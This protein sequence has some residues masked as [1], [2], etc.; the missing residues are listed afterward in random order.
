MKKVKSKIPFNYLTIKTT[1]SRIE[2]GLLAIPVSLISMFSQN[3]NKIYIIN[4]L[5]EEEIKKFTP[6]KSSSRE[7]RIGGLKNFYKRN[8]VVSGDEIVV[9]L[10]DDLR[11]RIIPEKKIKTQVCQIESQLDNSSDDTETK[12]SISRL[13]EVLNLSEEIVLKNEFV[14]LSNKVIPNRKMKLTVNSKTKENVSPSLRKI[15][16]SLYK[17]H[18]QLTN[19][20]FFMKNGNPYFE[21]HHIN[22]ERGNHFKNLL[23]VSPNIHAQFTYAN[24]EQ[25]FDR[26]GWLRKVIINNHE[27]KVKQCIDDLPRSFEKE[28][29]F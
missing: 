3:N 12:Q 11:Y 21:I 2:K 24:L 4:E 6:Y 26:D 18:C 10:L 25:F 20:T 5:G 19:F 15:L 13:V 16:L 7:C 22:S 14:R 28:V 1:K 23:V 17:G 27:Y 8:A 9:Q 29:H